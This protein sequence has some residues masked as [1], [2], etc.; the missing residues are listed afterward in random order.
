MK[1]LLC[2]LL[3]TV[4]LVSAVSVMVQAEEET[5]QPVILVDGVKDAVYSNNAMIPNDYW[6]YYNGNTTAYSP[7]DEERITNNLWFYWDDE[8]LYL[9]FECQY[10]LEDE[11][12]YQAPEGVDRTQA[13]ENGDFYEAVSV[14][15]DT[16]PS[17]AINQANDGSKPAEYCSHLNCNCNSGPGRYYRLQTRYAPAWDSWYNYYRTDEGM[18]LT[19]DQFVEKRYGES[20]YEDLQAMYLQEN[21]ASSAVGFVDY[22]TDTY[23]F[24]MKYPI[25]EGE[26]YFRIQIGTGAPEYEWEELGP[27]IPYT[28]AFGPA[29]W[30]NFD[31][32]LTVYYED[33]DLADPV[34]TE[35]TQV[36]QQI[37][38][39]PE[40]AK[41]G[42][43]HTE[44]INGVAAAYEALTDAQKEAVGE[45]VYAIL[46][47]AQERLA[48]L[49]VVDTLG[50][51][52]AS[53]KVDANDALKVLQASVGKAQLE[54]DALL[55]AD[56][57][58]DGALDAT[59][60]L[61]ILK[62]A[63]YKL[64]AFKAADILLEIK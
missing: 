55:R 37:R 36:I 50:D 1:K 61:D 28:I 51:V 47:A 39:I 4:L 14:W 38:Q 48:L 15:L 18:F 16:A 9:Y 31:S 29:W 62:F 13:T 63:V 24:E 54:A 21:G 46:V 5:E 27:E 6:D 25:A 60:A 22:D 26:E 12:L 42:K 23:G 58:G 49:Y 2:L 33:Y 7:V 64:D 8:F 57:T 45:D 43:T 56:V 3:A 11:H 20:G 30:M 35:V 17:I 34:D 41:I 32:M 40:L 44:Y 52:D 59:D 10:H 19:Y 53:G